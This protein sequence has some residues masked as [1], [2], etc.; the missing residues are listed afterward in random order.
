MIKKI[1]AVYFSGTGTTEKMVTHVAKSTA[2]KTGCEYE[3]FDFTRLD[4]R[5]NPIAGNKFSLRQA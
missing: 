4:M 2:D 3:V 1:W 5:K